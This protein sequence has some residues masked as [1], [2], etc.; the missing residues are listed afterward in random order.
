M[1]AT[2]SLLEKKQI[3]TNVYAFYFEKPEGF[4]YKA[5]QFVEI[6][7][8]TFKPAFFSL[9]SAPYED[10]LMIAT[11]WRSDSPFKEAFIKIDEL[12]IKG[13]FGNFVL[14]EDTSIPIVLLA[15]GIGITPFLSIAKQASYE[16][17]TTQIDLFYVN[18]T[19]QDALFYTKLNRPTLTPDK[20][21]EIMFT[22]LSLTKKHEPF[23]VELF[24][25][26]VQNPQFT[27]TPF[28][29]NARDIEDV[30]NYDKA[31]YYLC[32]SPTSVT[33]F[34]KLL[35]SVNIP[36][37]QVKVEDFPGYPTTF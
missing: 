23:M 22:S 11:R 19:T 33:N 36:K 27:F 12:P 9:A 3:A 29:P 28:L 20:E 8:P 32:G 21:K 2:L 4:T 30:P 25:L 26:Q 24:E 18:K 35:A 5:G 34:K 13:P 14:P 17:R 37:E 1:E 10:R 6:N 31:K 15:G 7:V 16:E